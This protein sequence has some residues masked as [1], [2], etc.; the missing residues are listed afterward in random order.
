M[1]IGPALYAGIHNLRVIAHPH[2]FFL[3]GADV[4]RGGR[5][6]GGWNFTG[7]KVDTVGENMVEA[8]LG[9]SQDGK[10]TYVELPH[11]PAGAVDGA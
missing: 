7:L 2:P 10:D 3:L 5:P 8:S 9:F 4:L 1:Q 6:A 11:A